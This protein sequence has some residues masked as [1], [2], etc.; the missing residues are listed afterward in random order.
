MGLASSAVATALGF[1]A[2]YGLARH[3]LPAE[4]LWRG[5]VVLPLNV[6]YLVI[7]LGLLIVMTWLG[8]PKSL[9][10]AGIGHVVIN[11][12]LAFLICLSQLGDIRR[13]S[14]PPP[15]ISARAKRGSWSP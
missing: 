5:L 13:G 10:T 15:A 9:A 1:L 3:R 4:S 14:R 11:L 12:P 8:L 2:A 6:S 7:G